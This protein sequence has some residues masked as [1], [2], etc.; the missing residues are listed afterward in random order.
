MNEIFTDISSAYPVFTPALVE[1]LEC[2]TNA[3]IELAGKAISRLSGVDYH[4]VEA[5]LNGTLAPEFGTILD[6]ITSD[7]IYMQ[8]R[9]LSIFDDVVPLLENS[10]QSKHQIWL[11]ARFLVA[12]NIEGV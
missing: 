8:Q 6:C 5:I 11:R 1:S 10:L 2:R 3:A 4:N 12:S 9:I 7:I